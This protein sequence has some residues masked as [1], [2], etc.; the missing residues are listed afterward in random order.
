MKAKAKCITISVVVLIVLSIS[1]SFLPISKGDQTSTS[2]DQAYWLQLARIA[3][4]YFQPGQ[5]VN[6]QTGLH[7]AG[8]Y[9]HYFTEWDLGT[10]IQAIIDAKELGIL[11]D[12]GQWGFNYR[13]GKIL[14][15]LQTREL[16]NNSIPYLWYDSTTGKPWGDTPSFSIDEGK[17]Y[18]A[19]Y[20]LKSL[21]PDLA[22]T[23]DYVVKVRNNNSDPNIVPDPKTWLEST[24]FYGYYVASAFK[25]FGFEGWDSV[26][27]SILTH[28]N[29]QPT[30]T[31][32]G[33]ELP[34]AHICSEPLLLTKFEINPQDAGF[35]WL[36]SQ[37]YSASEARYEATGN[38]TAFSEG[39][40]GLDDPGYIFEL[41]VD[42]DGSTWKITPQPTTPIAFFKVA[43]SYQAIFNTGYANNMVEFLRG[44]LP[45]YYSGFPEGV[46]EDG[47]RV[48]T[49]N[50]D[51]TNGLII[52][53]ARYAISNMFSSTPSPTPTSTPTPTP[54]ATFSPSSSPSTS[55]SPSPSQEVPSASPS[56]SPS[57]SSIPSPTDSPSPTTNPSVGWLAETTAITLFVISTCLFLSLAVVVYLR[58]FLKK[59]KNT[60]NS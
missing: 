12:D 2:N 37:V 33:V 49:L 58:K 52:A 41:A 26:P 15:F 39:N 31:T 5:G 38:Y 10:Y 17:L 34:K 51:R 47:S 25:A 36:L 6:A 30:V 27:S 44:K 56:P 11:Q 32:Y 16:T 8:L 53:A 40:T 50:I 29:S 1:Q 54:A 19:L 60:Q 20:N 9:W 48:V 24:D 46:V 35:T 59:T 21:R 28:I 4:Q 18:L 23:I 22:P 13:I 7:N 3:W 55:P 57:V 14:D 45:V 43:V 42:N